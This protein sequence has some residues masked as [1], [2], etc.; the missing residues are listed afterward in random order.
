MEVNEGEVGGSEIGEVKEERMRSAEMV[1][2]L[3]RQRFVSIVDLQEGGQEKTM[4][5]HERMMKRP[6]RQ[7]STTTTPRLISP[8]R[9]LTAGVGVKADSPVVWYVSILS[10]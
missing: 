10:R 8:S 6:S 1:R 5:T 9:S 4:Y 2:G 3:R 7:A